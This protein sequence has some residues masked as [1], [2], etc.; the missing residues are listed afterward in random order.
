M[1]WTPT[2]PASS[3]GENLRG[4]FRHGLPCGPFQSTES[5]TGH[6]FSSIHIA[7]VHDRA[8]MWDQKYWNPEFSNSGLHWG[9]ASVE[10]CFAGGFFRHLP[11]SDLF[12]PPVTEAAGGSA[13][14]CVSQVIAC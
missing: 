6:G 9:I 5:E 1:D 3:P 10:A 8:E 13:Q 7:F 2:S 11:K 4:I 12:L 14:L